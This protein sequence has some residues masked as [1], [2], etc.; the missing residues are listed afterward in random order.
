MKAVAL[1][2]LERRYPVRAE[3][4]QVSNNLPGAALRD[5]KRTQLKL[6]E[7]TAIR[8]GRSAEVYLALNEGRVATG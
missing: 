6:I 3:A 8:P 2:I 4:M 1:L 7:I 5:I